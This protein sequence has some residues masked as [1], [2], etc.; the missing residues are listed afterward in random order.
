MI[1]RILLTEFDGRGH[2]VSAVV[3][4][5]LAELRKIYR[6]VQK[7][8]I[9]C[10]VDGKI[11]GVMSYEIRKTGLYI[12]GLLVLKKYRGAG[13][14]RSL[15][16]EAKRIARRN[17]LSCLFIDTIKE[18]GNVPIFESWGFKAF[19]DEPDDKYES[20]SHESLSTVKMEMKV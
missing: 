20:D 4:S 2:E 5:G 16:N 1:N 13:V 14:G 8:Q 19:G 17:K 12:F 7:K 9:A 18:T 10:E 6:R 15:I 3:R 11:V